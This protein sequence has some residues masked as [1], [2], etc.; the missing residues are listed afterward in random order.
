MNYIMAL[1]LL[2]VELPRGSEVCFAEIKHEGEMS[3]M[4][5]KL[6]AGLV[7][8][9]FIIGQAGFAQASP[10]NLDYSVTDVASGLYNYEFTLTLDNND[11]SWQSG[12]GWSWLT[13]GDALSSA[14][15]LTNFVGDNS[16]LPI[17]PWYSYMT[18]SGGH[19]GPTFLYDDS[20]KIS[21]WTPTAIGQS[22]SWSGTSTADLAQDDLLFSTLLSIGTSTVK[23]DFQIAH[24][25]STAVPEPATMLL[26]GLGLMALA[27]ARRK[28]KK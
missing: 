22:L 11:S 15:P 3:F 28:I 5:R 14:S 17:G 8:G 4:I 25:I 12:Q 16:D 13:F 24:R 21:Y 19:N 20:Q 6:L 27:G 7:L 18:S 23:A 9:L 2:L 10:L 1:Y 26:F